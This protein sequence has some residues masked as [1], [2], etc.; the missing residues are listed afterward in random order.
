[1][2]AFPLIA[3]TGRLHPDTDTFFSLQI[4]GRVEVSQVEDMKG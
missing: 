1:M 3:F 2:G 4:Y